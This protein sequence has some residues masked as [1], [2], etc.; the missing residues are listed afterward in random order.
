MGEAGAATPNR[1]EPAQAHRQR[2][3]LA[4]LSA[5]DAARA[6]AILEEAAR[7]A[8]GDPTVH[9]TLGLARKR[10]GQLA[11]AIEAY[12]RALALDPAQPGTLANLG[13][14]LREAGRLDDAIACFRAAVKQKPSFA[15]AWSMASN[16]LREAKRPHDALDAARAALTI[17]PRLAEAHVNEAAALLALGQLGAAIPSLCVAAARSPTPSGAPVTRMLDE[18]LAAHARRG[19]PGDEPWIAAVRAIRAAQLGEPPAWAELGRQLAANKRFAP[20]IVALERALAMGGAKGPVARWLGEAL[21][22]VGSHDEAIE[23]LRRALADHPDDL[24]AHRRLAALVLQRGG[25]AEAEPHLRRALALGGDELSTL[26]NLGVALDRQGRPVEASEALARAVALDPRSIEAQINLG[27]ALTAQAR[28]GEAV[29]AYRAALAL[30]PGDARLWS[31]LLMALHFDPSA[32][33]DAIFDAHVDFGRRFGPSLRDPRP[34]ANDRTPGRRLRVGYLSPDL[35][36]HPV[37]YF[38]EPVLRAHDPADFEVIA[39]SDARRPDAVTERLRGLVSAL[40]PTR[41]LDDAALSARIRDDRID[42][43]VDL[44]G[45]TAD[46]RLLVFARK[47]APVQVSWIGYFDTTGLDAIDARIADDASV[48]AAGEARFVERVVRLPRSANCFLPPL[49]P[50]EAKV[51]ELPALRTGRPTFGCFNNPAKIGREV[52]RT[53]AAILRAVP[54]ARLVLKYGAFDDAGLRARYLGWLS[55]DGIEPS[56][57]ELRGHSSMRAFLASFADLDVALDPFPYSGETT[58]M[59]TLWMGVPLVTLEGETLVQRLGSRVVRV[60]GL[61]DWVAR[62]R[63]QYVAIAV[64]AVRDLDRLAG[65]RRTLRARV[66]ASPLRDAASVTRALEGAYRSLWEAWRSASPLQ[67]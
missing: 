4:A 17:D 43:L 8:P 38:L 21:A 14:A 29:A 35:R 50:S 58:A 53:F 11:P 64:D 1:A 10:A 61:G 34:H 2:L 47:P 32:S 26:V 60:A 15:E 63:D 27:T 48:P 31:N 5:G 45:H 3:A 49:E 44:C 23:A 41:G 52:V 22:A 59:H 20:A 40:V 7:E 25:H 12:R 56:R 37:A 24:A 42:V 18:A 33:P 36:Q 65:L 30:A 28:H 39:Y 55:E 66:E 19:A 16:A 54:D 6:V 57:V 62:D 46:N 67:G 13:R 51:S 9:A